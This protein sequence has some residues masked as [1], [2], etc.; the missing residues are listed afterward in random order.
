MPVMN[1][2]LILPGSRRLGYNIYGDE[3]GKSVLYFHG[4]PS[5]RIEWELFG[6][7][8]LL[9]KH[10]LRIIAVD[11]PGMGLSDFQHN[12]KITDW[13]ADVAAL[14]DH[15][16][17]DR[18][19]I[20]GFS[21]GCAYAAVCAL[22]LQD[23]LS[24]VGLASTIAPYDQPGL[25]DGISP[26]E[27][28]YMAIS[29]D[30]PM[31]ARFI[32]RIIGLTAKLAPKTMI[33][34]ASRSLPEPDQAVLCEPAMQR[35]FIR[36]IR[37]SVRK[38]PHGVQTDSALMVSPWGFDLTEINAP[39]YI[40]KG[41]LDRNAPVAMARYISAQVKTSELTVYPNDGHISIMVNQIEDILKV[42]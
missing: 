35:S 38:G 20:L 9:E 2:V 26:Q 28:Q 12:R 40:W 36:M 18:F 27:L 30:K 23:R 8:A 1:Q 10:K 16:H 37:E 29:R 25:T 17:L 6:T 39:V 21:G 22:K 33:A 4:T 3:H 24:I 14:A 41:E 31:L 5:A 34:Q 42:F 15:L 19:S 11:R 32:Q 13:P 7:Q